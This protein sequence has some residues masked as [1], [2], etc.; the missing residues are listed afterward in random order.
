MKPI[1]AVTKNSNVLSGLLLTAGLLVLFFMWM[2]G[3]HAEVEERALVTG[4]TGEQVQLRLESCVQARVNLVNVLAQAGWQDSAHIAQHWRAQVAAVYPFLPGIQALNHVD[5]DWKIS[6]VYPVAPNLAAMGA[7]LHE[8]PNL[9]VQESLARAEASNTI[10]RTDVVS[11]LQSGSGFVLYKK[12]LGPGGSNLG[13]VNGVFR[14]AD[15][16]ESCLPE[17]ELARNF[18]FKVLEADGQVVYASDSEPEPW[19]SAVTLA[20][21]IAERPWTMVLAPTP[22]LL[23]DQ[24]HY[25]HDMYMLI[26]ALFLAFAFLAVRSVLQQKKSLE[27]NQAKYRLLVE[28]QNDMVIKVD[29]NNRFTYVSPSYCEC[30]GKTEAELLGV[31][32]LP[33]VHEDDREVAEKSVA[34]LA[35]PPHE[36]YHEQRAMTRSGWRWLAWSIKGVLNDAGELEAV[37]GVGRDITEM[38]ALEES[39]AQTGKMRALGELA[40]G[41]SHDFNNLLQVMIGNLEFLL[42]QTKD[43]ATIPLLTKVRDAVERAMQLTEK[44]SGLSRQQPA[45]RQVI[46]FDQQVREFCELMAKTLP[47]QIDLMVEPAAQPLAVFADPTQ[48]ER[49][50]LNLIFNAR[51]AIDGAGEIKITLRSLVLDASFCR[52]HPGLVPGEYAALKVAD[53]GKGIPEADLGKIFDPFYTTKG[54]GAGSGL[55]LA[56]CFSIVEQHHGAITAESELGRGAAFTVYLPLAKDVSPDDQEQNQGKSWNSD[57]AILVVDD[58]EEIRAL[59]C[60]QL[61]Q[62]GFKTMQAADGQEAV[63]VHR[64]HTESI[65]MV[66]MDV[67]MPNMDGPEAAA[68]ILKESPELP[69]IYM[70]GYLPE[71]PD[72]ADTAGPLLKKPFKSEELLELVRQSL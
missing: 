24:V 51:D 48:L 65:G 14:I 15:L 72:L 17:E 37:T 27:E 29:M 32:Y 8:H 60:Q 59:A 62:A 16:M 5:P 49:V 41:I 25:V 42:D 28:N 3:R 11:L 23:A 22:Q 26:A 40:G 68:L 9:C 46:D 54:L 20:V 69:I 30:F 44:L 36:S 6:Q 61:Q 56:N 66:V 45:N 57:L 19:P 50:V 7:N 4:V 58:S 13:Y 53:S 2:V 55:G 1:Q 21:N 47:D 38:K 35:H 70:S 12:I 71:R 67:V 18:Q 43:K 10:V 63:E 31:E 52:L 33:L 39:M 34:R 64:Q